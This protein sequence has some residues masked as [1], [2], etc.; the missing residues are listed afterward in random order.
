LRET[1]AP[2][3]ETKKHVARRTGIRGETYAYWYL[4]RHGYVFVAR[5]FTS[6]GEIDMVGY[7]GK[8]L[9]FVEVRTRPV[10]EEMSALPEL[11][12]TPGK[13]HLLARTAQRFL[14][15]RRVLE[16]PCRFD[17]IAIDN[18]PGKPPVVRLHKDAFSPQM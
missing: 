3:P 8:T 14:A 17:V 15:E 5:N 13:Q 4:R 11:S 1:D 18:S 16:C 12:V 7:N 6:K 2:S 9:A 10:H